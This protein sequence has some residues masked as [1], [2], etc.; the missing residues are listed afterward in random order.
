MREKT[1]KEMID[2]GKSLLELA[3]MD[4]KKPGSLYVL[5]IVTFYLFF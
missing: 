2:N 1:N 3:S 5:N 4:L